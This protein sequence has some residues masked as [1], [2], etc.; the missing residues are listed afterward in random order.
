MREIKFRAWDK[1]TNSMT[2]VTT[3][4]FGTSGAECMVDSSGINLD[5]KGECELMQY[6]GLKD[7]NGVEIYEGDYVNVTG[8]GEHLFS[9]EVKWFGDRGY[10]AFD[11]EAPR[12]FYF[13]SNVLSCI[14][15]VSEYEIEVIGNKFDNPELLE[16]DM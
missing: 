12:T 5:I 9:S 4:D 2:D 8:E 15:N 10:P 14:S 11:I 13:D 16:G 7:K 6:T 3:L 1:N